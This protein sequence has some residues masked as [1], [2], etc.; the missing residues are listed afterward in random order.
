M[1]KQ[2]YGTAYYIAPEVLKEKYTEKCDIWS[3]GVILYVMLSGRPPFGGNTEEILEKVKTAKL[4]MD[5]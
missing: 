5:D 4:K 3:I 2:M 1:M